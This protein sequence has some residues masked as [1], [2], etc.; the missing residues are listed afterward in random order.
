MEDGSARH[1][2]QVDRIARGG[3]IDIEPNATI[4]R[5][6]PRKNSFDVGGREANTGSILNSPAREWRGN[7]YPMPKSK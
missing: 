6:A 1:L 2:G 4:A 7:E 5:R 3:Q